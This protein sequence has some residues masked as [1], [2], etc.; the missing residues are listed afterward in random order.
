[1]LAFTSNF[2]IFINFISLWLLGQAKNT[3]CKK[4]KAK[5]KSAFCLEILIFYFSL[6]KIYKEI[7]SELSAAK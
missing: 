2:L 6:L 5:L 1:V 7:H 3:R 4:Q